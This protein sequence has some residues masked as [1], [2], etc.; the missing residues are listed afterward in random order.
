MHERNI[1]ISL[2]N[3]G[4]WSTNNGEL[5]KKLLKYIDSDIICINET[6][7]QGD[8]TI[9]IEGFT[10]YGHN[11]HSTHI[12]APKGSGGVDIFVRNDLFSHF[13]ISIL[14]KSYDGILGISIISKETEYS[15]A[16]FSSYL[17]PESST[18]GRDATGFFTHLLAEIYTLSE[19]DS[20]ILCGDVNSRIG[21]LN[22]SISGI[23][24]IS[25]RKTID[26]TYN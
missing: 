15:N 1:N 9:D 5:R 23:D 24:E 22:D 18:W 10:F 19:Y 2:I 7:L 13:N 4:G 17:P 26:K 11:R 3:A 25:Q 14:D 6:H 20:I 8:T 16:I 12:R 21:L